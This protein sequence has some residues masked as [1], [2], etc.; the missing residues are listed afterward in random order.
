[1]RKYFEEITIFIVQLLVF[2]VFP[3][4][5]VPNEFL[6]FIVMIAL[7]TF[8]LSVGLG[9]IC[10]TRIKFYYPII[11]AILFIPAVYIYSAEFKI[12]D[13]LWC[14]ISSFIGILVGHIIMNK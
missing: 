13:G 7:A 8:L 4:F 6:G 9:G 1:M 3:I 12:I 5:A 11:I 10:K 14:L 2:Y